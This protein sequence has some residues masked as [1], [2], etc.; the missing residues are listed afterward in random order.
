MLN[1]NPIIHVYFVPGLAANPSIFEFI[2]LP[3]D[4][5]EIHWLEWQL[6][7]KNESLKNYAL[8]MNSYIEHKNI[9]LIGVSFGGIVV[10]EMSKYLDLK[11]LIIISSVKSRKEL[12]RRMRYASKA[13][14]IRYIP[15]SLL[16]YIDQFEKIA[17]GEFLQKRAKLYKK[18]LSIRDVDYVDWCLDSMINWKCDKPISGI[19]HIHGDEDVVFP[20]KYIDGCITLQGGTHIM[21]VNR[22]RWFNKYL[23]NIILTGKKQNKD[24]N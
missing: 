18:Y 15:T 20:Y 16:N 3:K 11:R 12:P 13:N 23:P 22:F 7:E 4:Q 10:Q 8:R 14:L 2:K 21:I 17:F 6:P 24:L 9:V 19:V 1:N 5:F